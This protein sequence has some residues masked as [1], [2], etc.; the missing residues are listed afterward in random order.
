MLE[1]AG[2]HQSVER[3][4]GGIADRFAQFAD[5][6]VIAIAVAINPV[7]RGTG[8]DVVELIEQ[9][10]FPSAVERGAVGVRAGFVE[11][12]HVIDGALGIGRPLDPLGCESE[13]HRIE[14]FRIAQE[15]FRLP[16]AA[17]IFRLSGVGAAVQLEIQLPHPDRQVAGIGLGLLEKR[18]G[19]F[20][21]HLG[22]SFEVA[23]PAGFFQHLDGGAAAAVAESI[24]EQGTRGAVVILEVLDVVSKFLGTD[25]GVVGVRRRKMSEDV[26]PVDALPEEGVMG[27]FVELAPGD[28]LREE[29]FDPRFFHDLRQRGGVPE[30]VG[31]PH[32]AGHIAELLLEIAFAVENLADQRFARGQVAIGLDPHGPDRLPLAAADGF[33]D[34]VPDFGIVGLHPGVL[35]SLGTHEDVFRIAVHVIQGGGKRAGAFADGLAQRPEP[36]RVDVGMADGGKGVGG[37]AVV[38]AQ[39]GPQG[40]AGGPDRGGVRLVEAVHRLVQRG[41]QFAP[42]LGILGQDLQGLGGELEVVASRWKTASSACSRRKRG[43]PS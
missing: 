35:L 13:G 41:A 24:D 34:A 16:V 27:K 26:G 15:E 21:D 28:F 32:V 20:R 9:N 12:G 10:Q 36:G 25:L 7:D 30:H 31:D 14:K 5:G 29:V 40:G 6:F 19:F 22:Q 42:A 4:Q 3:G 18:D 17:F 11:A 37:V 33:F 1:G 23:Q 39:H 2:V 38:A 43:W 8:N